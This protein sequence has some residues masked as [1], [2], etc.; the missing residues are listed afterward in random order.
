MMTF[1]RNALV[2]VVLL[3]AAVALFGYLVFRDGGLAASSEPGRLEE[4]VAERLVSLSIP[5]DAHERTNPLANGEAWR[6]AVGHYQDHC[7]VCH[8]KDGRA[9]TEIGANMYPRVT[10]L[11]SADTQEMS[12]G[13]LFYIIQ[14]GVRWTGM[15]A[16]KNEH[17]EEETWKLVSLIRRLPTLK[18]E[19]L[20][21]E[22]TRGEHQ[23]DG[24]KTKEGEPHE[25]PRQQ[26][27]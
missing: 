5:R 11:A 15:P 25:H 9:D 8:G 21:P 16:W 24:Q 2:T 18:A 1:L 13:A 6:E 12:D 19:E 20:A 26:P 14:N 23:D 22:T 17:T 4:S 3:A 10:D 27:H 7:A